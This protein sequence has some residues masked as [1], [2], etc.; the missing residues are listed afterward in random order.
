MLRYNRYIPTNLTYI[1]KLTIEAKKDWESGKKNTDATDRFSRMIV[2]NIIMMLLSI[3]AG[4]AEWKLAKKVFKA[5]AS[6]LTTV[7][8]LFP[9]VLNFITNNPTLDVLSSAGFS[10]SKIFY[11][12]GIGDEP[13]PVKVNKTLNELYVHAFS[14]FDDDDEDKESGIRDWSLP[15]NKK[16]DK[17]DSSSGGV[18]D[19][20]F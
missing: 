18:K 14:W 2:T 10:I 1:R 9:N 13:Y 20:S 8:D 17:K 19:W 6:L 3:L 7:V 16:S 11:F 4:V 12:L 15:S 5:G